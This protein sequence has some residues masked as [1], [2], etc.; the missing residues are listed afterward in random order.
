[1]CKIC[2]KHLFTERSCWR[3]LT[4]GN[5]VQHQKGAIWPG[6]GTQEK[7]KDARCKS[8]TCGILSKINWW[9]VATFSNSLLTNCGLHNG[10]PS[11]RTT[12]RSGG[13][14][15]SHRRS[16]HQTPSIFTNSMPT[17]RLHLASVLNL[18]LPQM[19]L[20]AGM[21]S[22]GERRQISARPCLGVTRNVQ[23]VKE[24]H[25]PF[26]QSELPLNNHQS[27]VLSEAEQNWHETVPLCASPSP[28]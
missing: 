9:L 26:I 12:W 14:V 24:S 8:W 21:I 10:M 4:G 2:S 3:K 5:W 20:D 16:L 23:M 28:W 18:C 15:W 19:D 7:Q 25:Q 17:R 11:T 27:A 1:M 6:R 22:R 13:S